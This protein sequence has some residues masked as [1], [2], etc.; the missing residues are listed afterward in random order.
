MHLHFGALQ[1]AACKKVKRFA[2]RVAPVAQTTHPTQAGLARGLN[3]LVVP[4]F[5]RRGNLRGLRG[6][7]NAATP[8]ETPLSPAERNMYPS[9]GHMWSHARADI[10]LLIF[11]C[12]YLFN[13]Y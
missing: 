8:N 4:P 5:L 11:T 3:A 12:N 2:E 13:L 9:R 7:S 1:R 10:E 6:C